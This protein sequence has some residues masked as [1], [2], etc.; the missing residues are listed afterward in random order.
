MIL[1]PYQI[2]AIEMVRD[3]YLAGKRA[4]V[5]VLPTGSGKTVVASQIIRQ[6][7]DRERR[8]LFLAPR[9]ELVYQTAE[10]LSRFGVDAGIVMAGEGSR[11]W[12]LAQVGSIDTVIAR[13]R[14]GGKAIQHAPDLVI[15]DEC[16]LG[17]SPIRQ[18]MLAEWGDALR[19]GLTATPT[20]KDGKAL[21]KLYDELLVPVTVAELTEAGHLCPA[22][23][24]SISEPDLSRVR[25]SAGDYNVKDLDAAVAPLVGNVVETW[26]ARA[27]GR[28]TVVYAVSIAHSA[29][30]CREFARAGIAAEH[31]DAKTPLEE[32]SGIFDRFRAGTTQVLTNCFLAAYG[33]DVPEIA[34]VVLARPTRSLMMYLQ[35]LGRGLRPA[36]GSENCLVLDHSG[37]VHEHGFA[38]DPRDWTLEGDYALARK[39]ERKTKKSSG[40]LVNCPECRAVYSGRRD[41]PECGYVRPVRGVEVE[42]LDGEL[43]EIGAGMGAERI[44]QMR[45]YVELAGLAAERGWKSGWAAHKYK[46]K[47][48][49][50]PPRA[51][52]GMALARPSSE[53]RRWV[54]SR[55]I[56]W[57]KVQEKVQEKKFGSG[58]KLA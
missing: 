30:L 51:W 44:D 53:V 32:R 17:I 49:Q 35:M 2:R 16:H 56:A 25:V 40:K 52:S 47:F 24:F 10:K 7:V 41:C 54:Q 27:G 4:P 55:I 28:R 42:T 36:E 14:R 45:W 3:S 48:G 37:A 15:V 50:W 33:L 21:G 39:T 58:V 19:L 5:L 22:R 46:E 23:Y 57:R 43:V 12:M 20:R 31:V 13:Q 1:R 18:K 29:A 34:C 6:A 11:Q 9:R 8:V 26:L 38:A